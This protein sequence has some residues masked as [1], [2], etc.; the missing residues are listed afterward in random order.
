MHSVAVARDGR[1]FVC[2]REN[3]RVQIFTPDGEYLEEWA[4]QRPSHLEF[5]TR[6]YAFVSELAWAAGQENGRGE[7]VPEFL[8]PRVTVFD[9]TGAVVTRLG[10]VPP[11]SQAVSQLRMG[12]P[13]TREVTCTLRRLRRPT[14]AS[15]GHRGTVR[16]SRNSLAKRMTSEFNC[17]HDVAIVVP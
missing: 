17:S 4:A 15:A 14:T 2:D 9:R 7:L 3:D 12:S 16:P 13:S 8:Q 1:V 10:E 11:G 5:D 6:G